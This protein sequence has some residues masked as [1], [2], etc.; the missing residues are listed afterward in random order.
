MGKVGHVCYCT[1]KLQHIDLFP[2]K[3]NHFLHRLQNWHNI[4]TVVLVR[5]VLEQ[6]PLLLPPY[7]LQILIV[8]KPSRWWPWKIQFDNASFCGHYSFR[9]ISQIF[10]LCFNRFT[11][12]KL[13]V[14][15][16]IWGNRCVL[17]IVGVI[18]LFVWE[19]TFGLWSFVCSQKESR[20]FATLRKLIMSHS[21][22]SPSL[23][24][25][26][27]FSLLISVHSIYCSL[28]W[29]GNK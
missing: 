22:I 12:A 5:K 13:A 2:G 18:E 3:S 23:N 16:V 11:A 8:L 21:W 6:A 4:F 9:K 10:M 15:G 24:E 7:V 27:W 17:Q 19:K 20:L 1:N 25:T 29:I 28:T 14:N 26:N